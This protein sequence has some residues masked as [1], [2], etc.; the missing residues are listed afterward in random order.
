ME[1]QKNIARLQRR[2]SLVHGG[3]RRGAKGGQASTQ[4]SS[5]RGKEWGPRPRRQRRRWSRSPSSPAAENEAADDLLAQASP[6]GRGEEMVGLR[7]WKEH[8]RRRLLRRGWRRG[9]TLACPCKGDGEDEEW[10]MA[11]RWQAR[12]DGGSTGGGVFYGGGWRRGPTP[13]CPCEGDEKT[14]SGA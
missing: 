10:G 5:A 4:Q 12:M 1:T 6:A 14:R 9:P 7:G 11:R 3:P 2:K 13:A 8:R